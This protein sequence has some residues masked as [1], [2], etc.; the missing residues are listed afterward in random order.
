MDE[1][2]TEGLEKIEGCADRK[3][4]LKY[5]GRRKRD[6]EDGPTDQSPLIT[7]LARAGDVNAI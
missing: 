4:G 7:Q 1:E 5:R 2:Q 6:G 3:E